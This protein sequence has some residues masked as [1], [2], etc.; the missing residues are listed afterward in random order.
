MG[1]FG[2]IIYIS[3]DCLKFRRWV[4]C[5]MFITVSMFIF[6]IF[7]SFIFFGEIWSQNLK[8]FKLIEIWYRGRLPYD[9][10]FYFFQIF[11]KPYSGG[12]TSPIIWS[13]TKWLKFHRGVHCRMP[14]TIL[15]FIFSKFLSVM[16]FGQIWSQNL[17][18]SKLIEIS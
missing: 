9:F 13:S 14:I 15:M 3:S 11:C 12:E 17:K 1:K 7:L 8:F 16:F 6:S 5:Y 10:Y 18:F 2:P 4:H